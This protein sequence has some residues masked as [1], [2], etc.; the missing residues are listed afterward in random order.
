[1]T[2]EVTTTLLE[3]FSTIEISYEHM[4]AYAA[5]GRDFE[6][7]KTTPSIRDS[8]TALYHSLEEVARAAESDRGHISGSGT[9]SLGDFR[10]V[11][12]ADADRARAT[13]K[14]ALS[15]ES[16]DSQ[17]VDNLN[18]SVHLRAVLTDLFLI[19]AANRST[20]R[21]RSGGREQG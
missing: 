2:E 15:L 20:T 11:L 9:L 18:I 17:V 6:D 8:L 10:N 7:R 13:V 1:M 5:Q 21:T 3:A 12:R 19:D 16:I 4:L 14:V